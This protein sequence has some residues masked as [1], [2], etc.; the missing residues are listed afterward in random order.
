M[1]EYLISN[2]NW[3]TFFIALGVFALIS[4]LLSLITGYSGLRRGKKYLKE[5][6]AELANLQQRL[7]AKNTELSD[8]LSRKEK[9]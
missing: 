3:P 4:N 9:K 1:I 8:L 6:N 5:S 7:R 2:F